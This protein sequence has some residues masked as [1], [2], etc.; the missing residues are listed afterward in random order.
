MACDPTDPLTW[1]LCGPDAA[2]SVVSDVTASAWDAVCLSFAKAAGMMLHAFA[3]AFVNFPDINLQSGGVRGVYSISLGLSAVVAA[4]LMLLQ[5]ARTAATHEGAHLAQALLGLGKA[6]VAFLATLTVAGAGLFASDDLSRWIINGAFGSPQQLQDKLTGVFNQIPT[7]TGSL[8]LVLAVV[9]IVLVTVLWFELLMRNAALVVIVS[10]SPVAATGQMSDATRAWWTKSVT[11]A[12]QLLAVK[13]A[14]ALV[15]AIGFSL[16][17]TDSAN[18][19]LGTLLTG[20]LVLLLAVLAWP[21]I[22]RFFTF[23]TTHVGGGAGLAGVIGFAAGRLSGAGGGPPSGVA[24]E[25]FGQAAEA[26]T[27]G[28]VASR[29]GAGAGAGATSGA[30][31]SSATGAAASAG[32][33][34]AVAAPIAVIAAGLDMAQRAANSLATRSEQMAGHAGLGGNQY[35]HP[36]GYPSH[37]PRHSAQPASPDSI[38]DSPEGQPPVPAPGTSVPSPAPHDGASTSSP[39]P[40]PSA[41]PSSAAPSPPA[42]VI[43]PP[44]PPS[45][46]ARAQNL[47]PTDPD[48]SQ[49]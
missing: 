3:Q 27:M 6:V 34:G 39:Q 22:A 2:G 10:T 28:A 8:V 36:A 12:I 38:E 1:P 17:T 13:P 46:P 47:P 26:R 19:D 40:P 42:T 4:V 14:I 30:T 15:F 11:A 31:G 44:P 7:E 25:Q 16:T 48:G 41:S 45:W 29:G 23:T 35:P 24:P 37:V 33:A 49:P 43:Q 9:G 5:T 18:Q 32:A 20:M 21:L